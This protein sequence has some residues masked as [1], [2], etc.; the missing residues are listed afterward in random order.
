MC[1]L[2]SSVMKTI[3]RSACGAL[4]LIH[5]LLFAEDYN[6]RDQFQDEFRGLEA[7]AFTAMDLGSHFKELQKTK[8][9]GI[10][11]ALDILVFIKVSLFSIATA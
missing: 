9:K 4:C 7:S 5:D 6:Y 11:Q 2:K 1:G 8:K 3:K 10:N